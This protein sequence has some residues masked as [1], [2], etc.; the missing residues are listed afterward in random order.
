MEKMFGALGLAWAP[1]RVCRL[2]RS[3][4]TR[5]GDEACWLRHALG[6]TVSSLENYRKALFRKFNLRSKTGLVL[7]AMRLGVVK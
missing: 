4:T 1:E 5:Y 2:L 7:F 3:S 6:V